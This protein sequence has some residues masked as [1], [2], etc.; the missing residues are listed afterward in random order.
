MRLADKSIIVTGATG[1]AA[2]GARKVAREGGKVFVISL[3]EEESRSLVSELEVAGGVAGYA[4][5]DLTLEAEADHAFAAASSFLGRT[6]GLFAVA[7]GSGRKFGDGPTH[8]MTLEAW[9]KTLQANVDPMFLAVRNTIRLI[10]DSGGSVV[11]V[12][13]VLATHPIPSF[14]ATHAYAASKGAANAYVKS[15]AAHYAESRIR[16]NAIAPGLVR[17]P[18]SERAAGDPETVAFVTQKQ[19]LAGGFLNAEDVASAV[20]FLLS[21]ESSQITGQVL[22]VDGGWSVTDT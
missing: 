1:I 4:T 11:V 19:P 5:A 17:T 7:G 20:V 9:D 12:S 6:D 22:S 15:L 3:D 18:M 21:D 16:V 13:S 10:G 14:F 8:E 2:A